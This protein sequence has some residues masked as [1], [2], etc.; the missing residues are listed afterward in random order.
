MTALDP[1]TDAG[2]VQLA[3]ETSEK[4][5]SR[6]VDVVVGYQATQWKRRGLHAPKSPTLTRMV[7]L[8]CTDCCGGNVAEVR[9]CQAVTCPLY[10]FRMGVDMRK[11]A[12]GK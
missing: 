7:R 5:T 11:R 9:R 2:R 3:L 10:L 4:P 6:A 1:D 8:M 12:R